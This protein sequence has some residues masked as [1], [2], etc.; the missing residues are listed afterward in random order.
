MSRLSHIARDLQ[1]RIERLFDAPLDANA[2]PLEICQAVMD[3]VERKLQP[4]GRGRKTFPYTRLIV[5]VR[6]TNGERAP[7]DAVFAGLSGRLRERLGELGCEAPH[8]LD[9]KVHVLKKVPAEWT[10]NQLFAVEYHAAAEGAADNGSPPCSVIITVLKGATSKKA[11]TFTEPVISIGRTP[12]PTDEEGRVRRNRIAFLD[13]TDGITE[14]V[15]RVHAHLRFDPRTREYRL[16]DDG[17]SNGTCIVREGTAIPV[18]P[19]DPRGIR[20]LSGDEIQVGRAVLRLAIG[21][22]CAAR[23]R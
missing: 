8:A 5:R 23:T 21:S 9:V 15:G 1:G 22:E 6:Q 7:L 3:D 20:V 14:T 19:R 10:P 17:S 13:T 18:P 16:F 2:T 4:V 11:F 12:D